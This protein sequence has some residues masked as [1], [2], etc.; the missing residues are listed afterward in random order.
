MSASQV[1]RG[2]APTRSAGRAVASGASWQLLSFLARVVA[3]LG[4]ALLVAHDGGPRELGTFQ[5]ALNVGGLLSFLIGFGLPNLITREVARDR[6]ATLPWLESVLLASLGSGALLTLATGGLWWSVGADPELGL[7]I[8]LA[9]VATTW[10]ACARQVFAAFWGWE[11]MHLETAATWAQ[12]ALFLALTIVTLAQGAG[13]LGVL[14]AYLASRLAGAVVGWALACRMTGR[15]LRPVAR[16][17]LLRQ[18]LRRSVPFALDDLLSMAYIRVDSVLLGAMKG[19]VAVGL[20]QAGTN[21]VLNFNVLARMVNS[22]LL[23]RMSRSWTSGS[24][25]LQRLRDLSLR[26]LTTVGVP[27][28][29]GAIVLAGDLVPFL[30]GPGFERAVLCFQVLSLVIP[31]RMVG[32][33]LGTALTAVDAQTSRTWAVAVA[34]LGN[35]A[36]NIALVPR[37]SYLGAA[38]ATVLTESGLLVAYAVLAQRRLG[39]SALLRGVPVPAGAGA[40]M[41]LVLLATGSTGLALRICYGVVA[42]AIA[43]LALV[44]LRHPASIRSPRRLIS[45]YFGGPA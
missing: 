6:A 18:I 16:P 4:A 40:L 13:A 20:Y 15:L 33:T 5:L 7:A 19:T 10:D 3:G 30:Y 41:F 43:F 1:E 2:P 17:A 9:L 12:E 34:A 42:Y 32:H 25:E 11:R 37:W 24:A 14:V 27:A 23:A 22:T 29:I 36:L 35:V 31:V 39:R 28:T 21:L 26:L 44:S 8:V 38:W 45:A